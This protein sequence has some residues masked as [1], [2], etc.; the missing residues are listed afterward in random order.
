MF[1]KGSSIIKDA[2][3]LA[4]DYVP[5]EL[6][7]RETEMGLLEMLMRPV[8]DHGSSETAFVSGSVGSGKTAT[9]KRSGVSLWAVVIGLLAVSIIAGAALLIRQVLKG[10]DEED[11]KKADKKK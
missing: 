2:S 8:V 5:V 9:V 7:N 3:K 6:I 1:D 10:D 11:G 4:F